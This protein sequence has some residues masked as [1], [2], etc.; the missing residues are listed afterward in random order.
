[1]LHFPRNFTLALT[2]IALATACTASPTPARSTHTNSPVPSPT[3]S[4]GVVVPSVKGMDGAAAAGVLESAGFK[5]EGTWRGDKQIPDEALDASRTTPSAGQSADPGSLV[6]LELAVP[7]LPNYRLEVDG[8]TYRL[9]FTSMITA[10][11][12]RWVTWSLMRSQSSPGGYF[13]QMNCSTGG[14][15]ESDN[16]LANGKFA[17]GALGKAQTGLKAGTQET[18]L[19]DGVTCP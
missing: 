18:A 3:E 17:V 1:M 15:G 6:V 14:T 8:E 2:V 7:P 13:V 19:V 16:R 9:E 12:A 10:R 11:E 5:V 4:A